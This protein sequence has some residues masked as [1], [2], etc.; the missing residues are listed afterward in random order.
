MSALPRFELLVT[1][2]GLLEGPRVDSE[3][4]LYFSDTQNGGVYCRNPNGEIET[5]IPKRRG[6]GGIALHAD[7]GIVVSGRN[8][9]HVKDG[10]SRIVF[11]AEDIPG[12]NDLFTDARGHILVGSLRSHVF[13]A[14]EPRETGELYRV[15]GKNDPVLLYDDVAMSNGIGSSPDGCR[16]YH[17]DSARSQVLVH[18]VA[19]DGSFTNRKI[20]A[21]PPRG[22][23]D[24]LAV[25]EAGC[26]WIAAYGGGCVTRFTPDGHLD[27]HLEIPANLVTSL[28][29]GGPDRRDLYVVTA[30]NRNDP[31]LSGCIF[32][33]RVEVPGLPVA[34]ARV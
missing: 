33:T 12:F 2:R 23:P 1:G 19:D 17:S 21:E 7:G 11:G 22:V 10:E 13:R 20:F 24:G 27:R 28:C 25:D 32:R 30:D 9:C 29:F 14:D 26:V 31:K 16:L 34:L 6:V 4:R 5:A 18:D 8:V 15:D 3:N